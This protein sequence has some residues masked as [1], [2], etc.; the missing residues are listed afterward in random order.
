MQADLPDLGQ[1]WNS[2]SRHHGRSWFSLSSCRKTKF[3]EERYDKENRENVMHYNT[4]SNAAAVSH[5]QVT[6][7][8]STRKI[9]CESCRA[10]HV[11]MPKSSKYVN[12]S[13]RTQDVM[14]HNSP[15]PSRRMKLEKACSASLMEPSC[16]QH[17]Q[18]NLE[19]SIYRLLY[20]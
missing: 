20:M 4:P 12:F 19:V 3:S 10:L 2:Q 6:N 14:K 7:E 11:T 18:E 15:K 1:V 17:R 9:T 16:R 13:F 5:K 8:R